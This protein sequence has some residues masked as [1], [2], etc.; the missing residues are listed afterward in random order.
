MSQKNWL[1]QQERGSWSAHI[2]IFITLS[3]NQDARTPDGELAVPGGRPRCHGQGRQH[4]P[5]WCTSTQP[6][7]PHLSG[8]CRSLPRD[9]QRCCSHR[10]GAATPKHKELLVTTN[11]GFLLEMG[12]RSPET[13]PKPPVLLYKNPSQP[14]PTKAAALPSKRGAQATLCQT[15]WCARVDAELWAG[16]SQHPPLPR[17][18]RLQ[19]FMAGELG[20]STP[21][22]TKG[23]HQS[24]RI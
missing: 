22:G 11:G 12:I 1:T 21:A 5:G 8:C 18:R 9:R 17:T 23:S 14:L 24:S 19:V 15:V 10:R 4:C 20:L 16:W 3:S 7:A 2:S 6:L 13:F